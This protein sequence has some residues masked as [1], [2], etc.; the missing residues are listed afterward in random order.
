MA[1]ALLH[2]LYA[3]ARANVPAGKG[4]LQ[5]SA[6]SVRVSVIFLAAGG[7]QNAEGEHADNHRHDYERGRNVHGW[8]APRSS[9]YRLTNYSKPPE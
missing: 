2:G 3:V 7:K 8:E 1:F 5:E 9:I 4:A 6:A